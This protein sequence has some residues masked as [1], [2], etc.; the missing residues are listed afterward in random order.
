MIRFLIT[1]LLLSGNFCISQNKPAK[2]EFL[3]AIRDSLP[4]DCWRICD[5]DNSFSTKDT[6]Y[7]F[8][9]IVTNDKV[10]EGK[11]YD[12]CCNI[13]TW[14]FENRN[15]MTQY[16]EGWCGN[17]I[18]AIEL[19]SDKIKFKVIEKNNRTILVRFWRK[20]IL[21]SYYIIDLKKVVFGDN[22]KSKLITLVRIKD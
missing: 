11:Q 17:R 20:K 16:E 18:K 6:L 4:S 1:F 7:L 15:N 2:K 19:S 12:N 9:R 8:K 14:S 5:M 22:Q 10:I 13:I 3:K 21:D